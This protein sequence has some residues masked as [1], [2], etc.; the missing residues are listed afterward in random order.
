MSHDA[1]AYGLWT[2]AVLNA[3]VFIIFAFSFTK[4]KT[5][6]DWRSFGAFSAFVIALFAEMY[7]FPLTIYLLA[8]WLGSRYPR[9]D[10]FSHDAGHL[11]STLLGL[12]GNPHLSVL[13]LLSNLLIF[14]GFVLIS[15]AWGAAARGAANGRSCDDRPL[16]G[17]PPSAVPGLHRNPDR[18]PVAVA[19]AAHPADAPGAGGHVRAAGAA[20]GTGGGYRLR[21]GVDRLRGRNSGVDPEPSARNCT[22]RAAGIARCRMTIL[23]QT[24]LQ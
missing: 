8:G 19:D 24:S 11:W 15:L 23:R 13:H 2:V 21:R 18:F 6:R 14:G 1:P 16:C 5:E 12:Q 4:P 9:L 3:V 7:G 17:D 20:R 22:R 10:P